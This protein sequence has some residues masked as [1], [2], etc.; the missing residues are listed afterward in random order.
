MFCVS[1]PTHGNR[2]YHHHWPDY[3][4]SGL[5]CMHADSR[6]RCKKRGATKISPW[7]AG[8]CATSQRLRRGG[9]ACRH[10]VHATCKASI[11]ICSPSSRLWKSPL[12]MPPHVLYCSSVVVRRAACGCAFLPVGI[13]NVVVPCILDRSAVIERSD[14]PVMHLGSN[15]GVI[16]DTLH[17]AR[18]GAASSLMEVN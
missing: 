14:S 15:R 2:S 16:P 12:P 1:V 9:G 8:S 18:V 10:A 7:R 13:C 4:S 11:P 5:A 3:S 17:A 6:W